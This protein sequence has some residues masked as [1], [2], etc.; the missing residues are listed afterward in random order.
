MMICLDTS[1]RKREN[2]E[3][4]KVIIVTALHACRSR[5]PMLLLSKKIGKS[6]NPVP[7]EEVKG[8]FCLNFYYLSSLRRLANYVINL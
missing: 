5:V 1:Y 2:H 4:E 3:R 7:R 6:C 8:A